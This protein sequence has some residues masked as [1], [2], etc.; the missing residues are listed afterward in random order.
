MAISESPERIGG[1][2]VGLTWGPAFAGAIAASALAL[3]LNSFGTAIGLALSSASPTWKW[4][5]R[6]LGNP[7]ISTYFWVDFV[8]RQFNESLA[9]SLPNLKV[10]GVHRGY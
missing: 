2:G 3:V 1:P 7:H 6:R 5:W 10:V 8:A 4:E 9:C